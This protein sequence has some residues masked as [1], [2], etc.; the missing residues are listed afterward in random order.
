M[1]IILVLQKIIVSILIKGDIAEAAIRQGMTRNSITVGATGGWNSSY[2]NRHYF[3]V[4]TTDFE[5]T[6]AEIRGGLDGIILSELGLSNVDVFP[7]LKLSQLID[8]YYTAV[9]K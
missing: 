4:R 1:S 2:A 9:R 3:H 8:M 6:D 7:E 5:L